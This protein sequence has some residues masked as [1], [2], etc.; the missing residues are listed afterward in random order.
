MG[1]AHEAK[2]DHREVKIKPL[3]TLDIRVAK[4]RLCK[5]RKLTPGLF[6]LPG[7]VI[8]CGMRGSGKSNAAISLY[9][10]YM[11]SEQPGFDQ[12][13][14]YMI[15]PSYWNDPKMLT[16]NVPE[17]N[18][19]TLPNDA[20]ISTI[21]EEI[22]D[23]IEEFKEFEKYQK[24]WKRFLKAKSIAHLDPD[25]LILLYQNNFQE[26]DPT[27][28]P[29]GMPAS[30]LF[31]DDVA[32]TDILKQGKSVLNNFWI[33]HRHQNTSC[34]IMTQFIKALPR[35]VRNN[36]CVICLFATK[37]GRVLD[38]I[39]HEISGIVAMED[40]MKYYEFA[41]RE[42]HDFLTIDLVG[43]K[44]RFRRN[45]KDVLQLQK[46]DGSIQHQERENPEAGVDKV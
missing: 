31:L 34:W 21:I 5:P 3:P 36:T 18:V 12:D 9:K 29:N 25:D 33:K 11:E 23:K 41:T 2:L 46:K 8:F 6:D 15:N 42:P 35:I 16:M 13:G 17:E 27:K 32:A 44:N 28:Y 19:H 45:F 30:L 1:D 7:T 39:Y 43:K 26:P 20:A 40:F 38:E 37:D 10:D 24:C 14:I 4:G 22:H